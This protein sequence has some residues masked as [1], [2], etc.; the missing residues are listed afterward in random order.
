MPASAIGACSKEERTSD[1]HVLAIEDRAPFLDGAVGGHEHGAALTAAADELE[2]QMRVVILERK[3]TDF[4][5]HQQLRLRCLVPASS[6]GGEL[7]LEPPFAIGLAQLRDQR[8]RRREQDRIAGD[9]GF[10]PARGP[11]DGSCP[12]PAGPGAAL[13]AI[14]NEAAR[15]D[16]ADLRL[17]E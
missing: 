2:D 16:L 17:V 5:D 12:R 9:N 6:V 7:V 13:L 10:A 15:C 3:I 14:G 1:V 8:R 11:P 4:I